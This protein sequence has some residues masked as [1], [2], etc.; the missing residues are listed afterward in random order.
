MRESIM[1][2]PAEY[3]RVVAMLK[4]QNDEEPLCL[5]VGIPHITVNNNLGNVPEIFRFAHPD[6]K[7]SF[8]PEGPVTLAELKEYTF[9]T[10]DSAYYSVIRLILIR[11][12]TP[13]YRHLSI[14]L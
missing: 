2:I 3:D 5:K 6:V 7:L 8:R 14:S 9:L 11:T 12:R 13:W 1:P 10:R 4:I